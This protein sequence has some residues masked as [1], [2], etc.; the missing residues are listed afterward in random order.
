MIWDVVDASGAKVDQVDLLDSVFGVPLNKHVLHSVVK[1]LRS[2]RRQGTHATKTR[3]LVSGSGK[4]PFKQKGTGRARQ[5]TSRAP[6][7]YHGAVAHG[8]QP[9]N[10]RQQVNKKTKQ[11]S[12]KIALSDKVR[13]SKL[14]VVNNFPIQ[15]YSTQAAFK[16]ITQL[17]PDSPVSRHGVLL[18]DDRADQFLYRSVRNI[19]GADLQSSS[20][21]NAEHIL[22]QSTLLISLVAVQALHQRLAPRGVLDEPL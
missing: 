17:A 11:L 16:L 7:M 5:G 4:K 18:L 3:S 8:P 1:A 22:A 12:V 9:R 15:T 21:L 13:H 20:S 10:Y 2:N 6:H 19:H 14:V